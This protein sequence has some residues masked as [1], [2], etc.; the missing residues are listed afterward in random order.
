MGHKFIKL[1]MAIFVVIALL[2]IGASLG[3]HCSRGDNYRDNEN[4]GRNN[5][6][7]SMG[8][9]CGMRNQQFQDNGAQYERGF[10]MMRG[11][12][13]QVSQPGFQVIETAIP[14]SAPTVNTTYIKV[15][16]STQAVPAK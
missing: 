13:V 15:G 7:Y 6:A 2:C 11:Q 4:F 1:A 12:T 10:N 16:T 9:G 8:G 5:S 14:A 3:R